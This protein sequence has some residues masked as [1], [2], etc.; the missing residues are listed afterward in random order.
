MKY[1]LLIL[2]LTCIA[3]AQD[4]PDAPELQP[5][6]RTFAFGQFDSP[7]P[8]RTKRQT[9]HDPAFWIPQV[10]TWVAVGADIAVNRNQKWGAAQTPMLHN[11]GLYLDALLP[12]AACNLLSYGA[13]RL[14]FRPLGWGLAS[15]VIF[16]HVRGAATQ[17]YP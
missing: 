9:L 7:K 4:L 13:D 5:A 1:A 12:V 17:K 14:M 2:A 15:Y 11:G 6:P 16:R 8:L 3:Q 10:A